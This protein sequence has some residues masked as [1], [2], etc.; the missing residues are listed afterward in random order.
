MSKRRLVITA[1]L[2]GG[3]QS[4]VARRYGV[5]QPW[6]S[7][8]MA[9]YRLEG[10]AAFEPRSRRPHTSPT[11]VPDKTLELVLRIRKELS[12]Q[13]LDSGPETICWHLSHH[14]QVTISRSTVSR[15]LTRHGLVVPDP[16]K[17]PRSSFLRFEAEQPNETWQSDFTHFRLTGRDGRPGQDLE[18]LSW[19]DDH[20]RFALSV[21][22]HYR[23]TGPIV[24]DTFRALPPASTRS[25]LTGRV[26][27]RCG[28]PV[29]P[30]VGRCR[31]WP[32]W[33]GA[34][35]TDADAAGCRW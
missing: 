3:S 28:R 31:R 33:P 22:A 34:T 8:L 30:S 24:L 29:R 27:R 11:A 17:R 4:E 18:I 2:A 15:V 14:H 12:E 20:S 23:V 16:A 26:R 5:S 19:L 21:T 35:G 13:G 10:E 7:R 25:V 32:G 9:R 6:I 1:V